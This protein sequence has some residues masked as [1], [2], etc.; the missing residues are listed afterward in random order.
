[1][2]IPL[3][4]VTRTCIALAAGPIVGLVVHSAGLRL[5]RRMVGAPPN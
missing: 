1:M 2:F 3:D 5:R 4:I